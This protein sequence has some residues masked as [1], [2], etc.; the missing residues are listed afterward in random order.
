MSTILVR[1]LMLSVCLTVPACA[2]AAEKAKE[3]QPG[4]STAPRPVKEVVLAVARHQLR[5]LADGEYKR[6]TW[7]EVRA[8]RAPEGVGWVYPWGV[9]LLGLLRTSEVT[10]D[11]ELEAFVLKHD[12]IVARYWDYLRWVQK[13]LGETQKAEVDALIQASPIRRVMRVSS[14]D[15]AGAMSAQMVEA[16]L[17]HGARPTPEQEELLAL[18]TDWVIHGQSRL[19]DGTF[20]R[21]ETNQTL[22]S[23]DLFM[24]GCLLTRWYEYTKD[25]TLVD[26][27]ARQVLGMASRQQDRDGLWFHANFIA[28]KQPS[29]FKWGRANGWA[30]VATAEVLSVLPENHPDRRKILAVFRK[31]LEGLKRVQ[32]PAGLWRQVLDHQEL[33]EEMSCTGMFTFSIAR[34]VRRGW[35]PKAE[36]ALAEKAFAGMSRNV[37]AEGQVAETSEG[38]LIGRELSYY[39]NRRRPLDDQHSPGPVLLAG[40]ELLAARETLA[41]RHE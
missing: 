39:A 2:L 14:L 29:P 28:E 32:A 4:S 25:R 5:P 9:T 23:D 19:P 27:A 16:F 7:E 20:W 33:W 31:Q 24:S 8:S 12:E 1:R 36:L 13:T 30:M 21:P 35:I 15:I 34:A 41:R 26:D 38:T 22:W 6:G 10:G 3:P 40:S 18:T 17:R 11:K 37:S